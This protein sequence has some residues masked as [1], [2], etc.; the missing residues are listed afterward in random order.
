MS[1][2]VKGCG[3]GTRGMLC[4]MQLANLQRKTPQSTS[5]WGGSQVGM[6][7]GGWGV[8]AEDRENG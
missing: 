4:A 2:A 8:W 3:L 7:D 5:V 6:G 1:S